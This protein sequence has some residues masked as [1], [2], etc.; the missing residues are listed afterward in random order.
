[1]TDPLPPVLRRGFRTGL[2]LAAVVFLSAC[3]VQL[4]VSQAE[5]AQAATD[6][7][8]ASP[9]AAAPRATAAA[10][11]TPHAVTVQNPLLSAT[12]VPPNGAPLPTRIATFANHVPPPH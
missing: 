2:G 3:G 11:P 4:P 6:V 9:A 5:L 8:A 10:A 12:Q 1:M 7:P